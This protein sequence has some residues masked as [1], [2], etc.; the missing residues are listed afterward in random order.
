MTHAKIRNTK[1]RSLAEMDFINP[2][3]IKDLIMDPNMYLLALR[4]AIYSLNPVLLE[5]ILI[6]RKIPLSSPE[7][8]GIIMSSI[9]NIIPEE[10]AY[11]VIKFIVREL[12]QELNPEQLENLSLP[13][14]ILRSCLQHQSHSIQL[15]KTS[16]C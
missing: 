16:F 6:I 3:P 13:N 7:I 10:G 9:V 1:V 15:S 5:S 14:T 4:S 12:R 2:K 11:G 8:L